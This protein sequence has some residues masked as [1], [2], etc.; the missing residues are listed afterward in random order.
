MP[1]VTF[2]PSTGQIRASIQQILLALQAQIIDT[3]GLDSAAVFITR[4]RDTVRT[5]AEASVAIWVRGEV[6]DGKALDG[7]GRVNDMRTR[8]LSLIIRTRTRLDTADRADASITD[9][10]LG[11]VTLEDAVTEAVQL[12]EAT[13]AQKQWLITCPSRAGI[14]GDPMPDPRNKD[15]TMSLVDLRVNYSRNL[16]QTRQ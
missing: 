9:F 10:S 14:V 13:N 8:N 4:E 3:T 11:S 5:V 6:P 1:P 7:A 16:D 15:F 12:F 2:T